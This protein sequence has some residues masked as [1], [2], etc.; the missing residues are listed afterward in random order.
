M[1]N[2]KNLSHYRYK[3]SNTKPTQAINPGSPYENRAK[4]QK[5]FFSPVELLA[6]IGRQPLKIREK[7][8]IANIIAESKGKSKFTPT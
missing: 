1:L 6:L 8:I 7:I 3:L 2:E 5:R 4:Q